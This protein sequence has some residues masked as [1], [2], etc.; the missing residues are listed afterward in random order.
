ME[1]ERTPS[2]KIMDNYT[3]TIFNKLDTNTDGV[4]DEEEYYNQFDD[5]YEERLDSI[6]DKLYGI[7]D[8]DNSNTITKDEST[9]LYNS[10]IADVHP[11]KVKEYI[12]QLQ[13]QLLTKLNN[14]L[15]DNIYAMSMPC[16]GNELTNGFE[17]EGMGTSC[18]YKTLPS[19]KKPDGVNP[20]PED[21]NTINILQ[22]LRLFNYL[23]IKHNISIVISLENTNHQFTLLENEIF[24]YVSKSSL[25][26]VTFG[27][28][29]NKPDNYEFH[30][31]P[32]T[33][34]RCV[35]VENY[36]KIFNI[37]YTKPKNSR[38]VIHCAAGW[39]RTGSVIYLFY[40][41]D[42]LMN[43]QDKYDSFATYTLS[44][45]KED[46]S[47]LLMGEIGN[48]VPLY[49]NH[50]AQEILFDSPILENCITNMYR[51]LKE[52]LEILDDDGNIIHDFDFDKMYTGAGIY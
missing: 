25:N 4:I 21:Y 45:F 16:P 18:T 42:K 12:G 30:S 2:E 27:E 43:D 41:L 40:Y 22:N 7:I 38:L 32:V 31:I 28:R 3:F 15:F 6:K 24:D 44:Q 35:S 36:H 29:E 47:E 34:H 9:E 51:F 17:N 26:N 23:I 52:I 1:L 33:D 20:N 37:M 5:L 50:S 39:G 48:D 11:S 14:F 13:W 10:L 49:S 19:F 8:I 46:F